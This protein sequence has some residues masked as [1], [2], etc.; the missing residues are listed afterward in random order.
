MLGLA[1]MSGTWDLMYTGPKL[2]L[3]QDARYLRS[4]GSYVTMRHFNLGAT[5]LLFTH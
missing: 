4:L 2:S 5:S 1:N 3:L